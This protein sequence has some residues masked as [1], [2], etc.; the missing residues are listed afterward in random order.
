MGDLTANFS[1]DEFT[2]S[3]TASRLGIDNDPTEEH[4]EHIRDDLAPF[5]QRLRDKVSRAVVILSGYRNPKVN[6]AVGGVPTSAH[7]LGW[8]ADIIVAGMSARSLA[9]LISEDE[10]LMEDVDQLILETS[11]GV[12]HVSVDPRRRRQVLTQPGGPGTPVKQGIL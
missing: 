8:A 3:S 5:L 12:V 6:K 1:L 9:I 11:R 7:A 2:A 10:E 4:L